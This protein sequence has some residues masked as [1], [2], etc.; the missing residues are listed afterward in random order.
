[1]PRASARSADVPALATALS[2]PE[3]FIEVLDSL[4][5]PVY[6]VDRGRTIRFWNR[7]C[8]R[9]TGY[10][11]VEVVGRRCFD[12]ILRHVDENGRRL[13]VGFCPLAHTMRDG[14]PRQTRVWL[15][16]KRGH[17]LPVFVGVNPIRDSAGQIIGAIE[18]FTDESTLAATQERVAEL[19]RLAMVDALT[20]VPNR[21]Y[22]ELTLPSR[23][24]ELRR[25]G[26]P[27]VAAFADID[28]FK[29]INDAHGHD[30][31]DAILRM[32][33]TT[34]AGNLRGSD[35]L[36]RYG[37]EEFVLLLHHTDAEA[38][39]SVCERLRKLVASSS[40]DTPGGPVSVTVSFGATLATPNDS[41]ESVL[42]RADALLYH[43]KE[44]GRDRIT[45]DLS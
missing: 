23:L 15:H 16:H 33:A 19:E 12:D 44:N 34:L 10:R 14:E 26:A 39:R 42:R 17:R 28:H 27:F 25:H 31:G 1:M 40:L 24:A 37:G 32:T 45:T 43:S 4:S 13:C 20:G 22:L 6:L 18:T 2:Q 7:A 38:S 35:E 5:D 41:P 29:Q 30:A 21:R 8:E 9:V 36:A 11:A 3:L